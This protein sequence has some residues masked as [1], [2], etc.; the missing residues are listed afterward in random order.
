MIS[1]R[2]RLYLITSKIKK[3]PQASKR[4][5]NSSWYGLIGAGNDLTR[6]PAPDRIE[7]QETRRHHRV[8]FLP[9]IERVI[10][11]RMSKSLCWAPSRQPKAS[12]STENERE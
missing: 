6:L 5:V 3:G 4:I 11:L 2:L 7:A 1:S 10:R 12:D 8:R 9:A